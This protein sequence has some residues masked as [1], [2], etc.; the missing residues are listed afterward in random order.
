MV[1]DRIL[2]YRIQIL[3][4]ARIPCVASNSRM[5]RSKIEN[6]IDMKE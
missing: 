5:V 2:L 3:S 1:Y 6:G 4:K